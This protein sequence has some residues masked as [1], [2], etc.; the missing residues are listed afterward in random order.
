MSTMSTMFL[1]SF[2]FLYIESALYKKIII[3]RS[4]IDIVDIGDT[5]ALMR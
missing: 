4:I 1:S 2:M 5:K 3:Y